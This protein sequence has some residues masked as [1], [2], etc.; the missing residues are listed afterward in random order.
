MCYGW[1]EE[2]GIKYWLLQNSWGKQ[3]GENGRFRMK[4]G[5]DESSIE[6]MAEAADIEI[7]HDS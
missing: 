4:R 2:N 3:W 7:I 6:S 1:G 5:L